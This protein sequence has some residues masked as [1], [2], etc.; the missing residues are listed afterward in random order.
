MNPRFKQSKRHMHVLFL[1]KNVH[2]PF[3][4]PELCSSVSARLPPY[5]L[6]RRGKQMANFKSLGEVAAQAKL[7]A[8]VEL[9]DR[10]QTAPLPA[11]CQG[12]QWTYASASSAEVG[13]TCMPPSVK[14]IWNV[15][16][17]PDDC[18]LHHAVVSTVVTAAVYAFVFH[19][20]V[21]ELVK[22]ILKRQSAPEP[23]PPQDIFIMRLYCCALLSHENPSSCSAHAPIK[24][25]LV[26]EIQLDCFR[27]R[28]IQPSPDIREGKA[29]AHAV[30]IPC[31]RARVLEPAVS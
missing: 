22:R 25:R 4:F 30:K 15:P 10:H 2:M 17:A 9:I 19:V 27:N 26:A 21:A 16:T 20:T 31:R 6:L 14:R 8:Q 28:Q 18:D 12:L 1:K 23:A 5:P 11:G 24:H 7:S 13:R 3:Y 29:V